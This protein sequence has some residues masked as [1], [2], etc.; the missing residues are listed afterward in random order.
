MRAS[1][2]FA[3]IS[4]TALMALMPANAE[5]LTVEALHQDAGL[6][7]PSLRGAG[8][9]PDGSMVTLLRGRED[10]ARI[11]DLWAYDAATGEAR[12]LVR[13]DEL[14]G[15][16]TNLSKEEKNRRERQRIYD[17]G[18]ISYQWDKKGHQLLFPLG[19][20]VYTYDVAS[21]TPQQITNSESFETDPK[22]SPG[23]GYVSYV[24][25]DELFVY[26]LNTSREKKLTR[27]A[28]MTVRNAVAEFVAQEELDRDTGYWWSPNDELIAYTQIDESPVAI[29]ERL[30]F[31]TEGT[32]TIRQR[33]PF[34]GTDNVTIRVGVVRANGGR[35]KWVDLGDNPDIYVASAHWSMDSQTLYVVRLSRD[36]KTLDML[37]V[38]PRTGSSQI[39][40]TESSKTW[41]NLQRGFHALPDGGFLWASERDGFNH[42]YRYDAEGNATQL[43]QG[44]WPVGQVV[45]ID[46]KDEDILFTGWRKTPTENHLFRVSLNGGD[47]E[48]LTIT[49]GWHRTQF[50]KGCETYI[51]R[52][53]S[54][55]QPP[56]AS[57]A[58]LSDGRKFWLLENAI[59]G[60][61]PYAPYL[62][63]HGAWTLGTLKAEDG[64]MMDYA[65][66]KPK[67]LQSG[68]QAPAIQLVYGGPGVQRV[69]NRWGRQ[70]YAQ[71]LADQ[72]YVVFQLGNRGATNR[73]K[74]FEDVIYRRMGQSEVADQALGTKWLASQPFVD[75]GR[76][77]VQGWSYGGYMTLMM[78]GQN[79]DLYAAGVSGAP[80]T[81][82]RTYDTAY[83]ERYMGDPRKV[84]EAYDASSV[85]TYAEGIKDDTLLLIHGMADDNVIFQNA[86]DIMAAL[87]RQGT[88]FDL[89]TYP[90]EKHGFRAKENK[91]HRDEIGLEFFK[92][93]L[94]E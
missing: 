64:Q 74:A 20:D 80:V 14:V 27:G 88:A 62:D 32:K 71:L 41:I 92:E 69:A 85:L 3:S 43:T 66:L 12:I 86:I 5:D 81:D 10:N 22:L 63:S 16:E 1:A 7:G 60:D 73:G 65:L 56:Q 54:F 89:M 52:F 23:G 6:S 47:A 75:P 49:P 19:G 50:A 39:V 17:S 55:T 90:G 79:P 82:W 15:E 94:G 38:D 67:G 4:C 58:T 51:H 87:Q 21:G 28:T 26:D 59:E 11:L 40:F 46:T 33:Y 18:I 37:A 31:S 44:D 25:E 45:C 78:L 48:Q 70:L 72:G 13:S 36:Q 9:S 68:Q 30:D 84:P 83:T 42:I 29:A 91:I 61:H 53:S 34:A 93:R 24:R 35:T 77:G 57:V 8:F 76:V 2:F